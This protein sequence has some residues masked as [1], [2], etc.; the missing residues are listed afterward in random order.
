MNKEEMDRSEY[1]HVFKCYIDGKDENSNIKVPI[2][3]DK[4]HCRITVGEITLFDWDMQ[5]LLNLERTSW[6]SAEVTMKDLEPDLILISDLR[7]KDGRPDRRIAVVVNKEQLVTLAREN[8]FCQFDQDVLCRTCIYRH[9]IFGSNDASCMRERFKT[10]REYEEHSKKYLNH[11]F[12][13]DDA[14]FESRVYLKFTF[15]AKKV[16]S[17]GTSYDREGFG[18]KCTL[19]QNIGLHL[20]REGYQE[21]VDKENTCIIYKLGWG[22][23]PGTARTITLYSNGEGRIESHSEGG[24]CYRATDSGMGVAYQNGEIIEGLRDLC[25]HND[26]RIKLVEATETKEIPCYECEHG[27]RDEEDD[28][29]D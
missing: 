20:K 5:R 12:N 18:G 7:Y 3:I 24:E 2:I 11:V 19:L 26:E 10:F 4:E 15:N 1:P 16:T 13:C 29:F 17:T 14:F 23:S 8:L 6:S 28:Y 22:Y 27:E 25:E 21:Q 9:A